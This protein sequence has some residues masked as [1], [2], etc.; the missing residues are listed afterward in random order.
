[1]SYLSLFIAAFL[2]ATLLPAQSEALLLALVLDNP[3]VVGWLILT[4]TIGNTLGSVLNWWLGR[5]LHHFQ[6][7]RW[8]PVSKKSLGYAEQRFRKYGKWSLLLSW[9]PII[10]DP[11][12]VIAGL[13]KVPFR[14]FLI[15]VS[16]AKG[17]RYLVIGGVVLL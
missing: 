14:T 4:A 17:L 8:F 6:D 15:L 1:M 7:K 9:M 12:T 11:L 3:S 13:L 10:G 16:I 2:A 5:Y